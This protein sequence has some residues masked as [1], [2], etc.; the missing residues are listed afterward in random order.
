MKR[1]LVKISFVLTLIIFLMSFVII[2]SSTNI[3][4]S[5]GDRAIQS[6]GGK[7]NTQRYMRIIQSTTDDYRAS[8][9]I[10]ASISGLGILISGIGIYK[11]LH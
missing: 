9:I 8:G 6:Y 3:G 10:L 1:D 4:Q 7:M 11:E 5:A 2:L